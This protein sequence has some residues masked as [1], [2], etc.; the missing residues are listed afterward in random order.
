[1][2]MSLKRQKA[3]LNKERGQLAMKKAGMSEVEW[4]QKHDP[5]LRVKGKER[6]RR[7]HA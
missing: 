4:S 1:M 2:K 3:K 7:V 6:H 5:L